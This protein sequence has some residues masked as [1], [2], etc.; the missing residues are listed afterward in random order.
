MS[1]EPEKGPT[2][3]EPIAMRVRL[4]ESPLV[5]AI[6]V[7]FG[8][9]LGLLFLS[10][11]VWVLVIALLGLI[12]AAAMMPIVRAMRRFA[13][14]PGGWRVPKAAAVVIIYVLAALI[15]GA[16]GYL[17]G[18]IIIS[19][20]A[21]FAATAPEIAA[22]IAQQ[23]EDLERAAGVPIPL[24]S[25]EDIAARVQAITLQLGVVVQNVVDLF[26]QFF[27]LITLALFLIVESD[28]ILLFWLNFFPP[29]QRERVQALTVGL[30]HKIGRWLLGQIAYATIVGVM[31]GLSSALLGLPYPALIAL[32]TTIIEL[33]PVVG[34]TLMVIPGFILG[35]TQSPLMAVVAAVV[36]FAIAQ[37]GGNVLSPLI[38][39]EAVKL[40]PTL[41][42]IAVPFGLALY[43]AVGALIAIPVT[44]AIQVFTE[45]VFL[46]W[47]KRREG[48]PPDERPQLATEDDD[49]GGRG[50]SGNR[51]DRQ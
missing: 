8:V 19:E 38:M 9:Y 16:I 13:F 25:P 36:F 15:L 42:I 35:L 33:L 40:S 6:L 48:L 3:S 23:V 46:P 49:A 4:I 21:A 45:D 5:L 24:P 26:V 11:V 28:R 39:G 14:P 29:G 10:R 30:G 27:I 43:G 2:S 34:P 7:G 17:V 37:F 50:E 41:I 47:L 20:L 32:G 51:D 18:G 31:I 1:R 12:L 22:G 44:V